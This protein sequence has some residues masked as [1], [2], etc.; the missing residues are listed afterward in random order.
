[1]ETA[2]YDD[3]LIYRI[4]CESVCLSATES[5]R[6]PVDL[7]SKLVQLFCSPHSFLI[8]YYSY[9]LIPIE[10]YFHPGLPLIDIIHTIPA[11]AFAHAGE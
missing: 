2:C 5:Q 4:T 6:T 11:A 7:Q 3:R 10:S 1:M 9:C 8:P